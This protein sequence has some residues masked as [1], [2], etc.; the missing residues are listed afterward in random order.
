MRA[1]FY[2]DPETGEPHIW[3][4]DV[5]EDEAMDVLEQPTE[6]RAAKDGARMALGQTRDGRYLRVIYV[7]DKDKRAVFVV[8]AFELRGKPLAALKKRRQT[9]GHRQ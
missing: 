6:D 4:H 3:N 9:R 7:P 2:L 5:N 1:R 8:T